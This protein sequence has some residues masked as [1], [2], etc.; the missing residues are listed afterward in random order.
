MA[1]CIK[2]PRCK[3]WLILYTVA[4]IFSNPTPAGAGSRPH[5]VGAYG[6]DGLAGMAWLS[7]DTVAW[8]HRVLVCLQ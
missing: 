8:P 4:K 5:G 1:T 7:A 6:L 3:N 2:T